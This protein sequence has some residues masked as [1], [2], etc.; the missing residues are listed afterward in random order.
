[1]SSAFVCTNHVP[2]TGAVSESLQ[3]RPRIPVLQRYCRD[4]RRRPVATTTAARARHS[5]VAS[6][7]PLGQPLTKL[8]AIA[9]AGWWCTWFVGQSTSRAAEALAGD[10]RP[11]RVERDPPRGAKQLPR[12]PQGRSSMGLPEGAGG[13][14]SSEAAGCRVCARG[15]ISSS[16]VRQDPCGQRLLGL[17]LFFDLGPSSNAFRP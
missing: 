6:V 16:E 4:R 11:S 13:S 2:T 15:D 8:N 12:G 17:G 1:V 7:V 9:L 14:R 3:P 5:T 10:G